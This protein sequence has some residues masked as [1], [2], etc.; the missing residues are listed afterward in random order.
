MKNSMHHL[1]M[2]F[3]YLSLPKMN[4]IVFVIAFVSFHFIF[5]VSFVTTS[6]SFIEFLIM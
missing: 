2:N 4:Q 6:N 3:E 1:R 5:V